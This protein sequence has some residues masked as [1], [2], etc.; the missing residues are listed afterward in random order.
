MH[1]GVIGIAFRVTLVIQKWQSK[2]Q[3]IDIRGIQTNQKQQ[4]Y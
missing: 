3:D 2:S 4:K 1:N